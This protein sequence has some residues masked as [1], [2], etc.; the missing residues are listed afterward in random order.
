MTLAHGR[1]L[2]ELLGGGMG[3]TSLYFHWMS[4]FYVLESGWRY[5]MISF[6]LAV[7]AFLAAIGW[8]LEK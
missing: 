2:Y 5:T 8:R 6:T 3:T 4:S 1:C 7:V